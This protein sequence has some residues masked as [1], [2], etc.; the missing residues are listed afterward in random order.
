MA[1]AG[2]THDVT[3]KTIGGSNIGFMLRRDQNG[4]R[5]YSV[6]DAQTIAARLLTQDQ[7]TQSQLPPDLE[8]TFPQDNWKRGLGGI[9]YRKSPEML[10]DA[11][12]VDVTEAGVLKLARITTAT[13]VDSTPNAYV[14]SGFAVSGTQLWAFIGQD[15]YSWDF[16]NKN[17]DIKTEPLAA[18]RIYRNAV[19]Y[20]GSLYAPAWA[21]DAGSGGS[22]TSNDEPT[23]YIY[24]TQS[25]AQWSLITNKDA[26]LEACKHM[27][28]AGQSLWGGYWTDATDSGINLAAPA[29]TATARNSATSVGSA[30][31]ISVATSGSN[32]GLIVIVNTANVSGAGTFAAPT[33]VTYNGTA[34][35]QEGT[36]AS[37]SS[38]TS[39]YSLANPATGTNNL[40]VTHDYSG[41]SLNYQDIEIV[42][43]S[44]VNQSDIASGFVG[45]T[46]T[47]SATATSNDVTSPGPT[48]VIVGGI[49][50]ARN[51]S[52]TL[53]DT[54]AVGGGQT[55]VGTI[56]SDAVSAG[57]YKSA[58]SDL[59]TTMSYSYQDGSYVVTSNVSVQSG[60]GAS[61]TTLVVTGTPSSKF[62]AGSV[63]RIDSEL[64]LVT[65][66][67]DGAST[68]T[69][70]RGYRG[71]LA[72]A[73][74]E[75]DIFI[76]EENTNEVRS[77]SD[78]SS[79]AN[80][81]TATTVG[82]SASPITALCGVGNDLVVIKTD[83]IYRLEA[84]GTVTNLRPELAAFGHENFGKASW[85]W[86]DLVFIPMHNG[87]LWE[88]ETR[89]WTIR[90]IS[91]SLSAP[92][93]TQYHGRVVAG[94]GEPNR[95]YILVAETGSTKYHVL[96]TENPAQFGLDEYN[97][98]H[99]SSISYTTNTDQDHSAMLLQA[100][101]NGTDEHHRLLVGVESTGSNL[102]PY[103]IPHS[104]IDDDNEYTA[105]DGEAYTVAFD[106]GFPNVSKRAKDITVNTDNLGAAG[107]SNHNIHIRYRL[108]GTGDWL[109][110]NSG[111]TS[112][113]G[114]NSTLVQ[115][116]QTVAFSAGVTFKKIEF[117][118]TLD[119][120][121]SGNATTPELHDF[122]FTCQLRANTI[123]QLPLSIYLANGLPLL[124]GLMENKAKTNRDQLRSWQA[125]AA[126]I[127]LTDTEGSERNCI[128]LP[129]QMQETEV[130]RPFRGFPEYQVNVVLAEV[131]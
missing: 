106:A 19:S 121:A 78:G 90:D 29:V 5:S 38:R 41:G 131:G 128:F 62:S 87:G 67:S 123:K 93:Q 34:M 8:L 20:G 21:D 99:V 64:M 92:D 72:A 127:V 91:L 65:A 74:N 53:M 47:G 24:K 14:P 80:W 89:S 9:L 119:R 57:S 48:S 54:I 85:Q 70:V 61:D 118:F 58:D 114:N 25:A 97:W 94:H 124:N 103:Y 101:T 75:A 15:V 45:E 12:Y 42:S 102:L 55:A 33:S 30:T 111:T 82:D 3:I 77:T 125:Q 84:D 16:S 1:T 59:S 36:H 52:S 113:T 10:A 49:V 96:M 26:T 60:L 98:S 51:T 86:N 116:N 17:W 23:G 6:Q 11:S 39:I 109:Y 79:L 31:T 104:N 35:T 56:A 4:K 28:V 40:V 115:D 2:K 88:L 73:T 95:L 69:V 112:N 66:V 130:A 43:M 108:E 81:S 7:I 129:G 117:R 122:T 76:I 68:L 27:A 110:A 120:K 46:E 44:G 107:G 71:T 37:T 13:T 83:G 100:I 63:I 126:E 22:Y 50:G 18:A 105:T 32:R